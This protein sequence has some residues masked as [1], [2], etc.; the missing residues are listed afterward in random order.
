MIG[1]KKITIITHN[2]KFHTDDVFA[3]ATLQIALKS[4]SV[5]DKKIIVK[6]TRDKK[7]FDKGNYLVDIGGINDSDKNKF[8]HHQIGGA[9]EREN[10]IPYASFG[11]VWKKF[12]K[13]ICGSEEISSRIDEK[14]V[15]CA[16]AI[17]NG[18]DISEPIFP[19][20]RMYSV[21]DIV[22]SYRPTWKEI[23]K[24]IDKEFLKAVNWAKSVIERE[25]EKY[26]HFIE[27][28]KII[29]NRYNEARNKQL[30]IF[31][32]KNE[33][34]GREVIG[35]ILTQYPKVL[36][37]VFYRPDTQE[38]QILAINKNKDSFESRKPLPESWKGLRD[39]ELSEISGVDD[40]I[41]CHRTGFMCVTKTKEGAIKLAELALKD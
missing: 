33:G 22:D 41:F 18:V 6:R 23:G 35:G 29:E 7:W 25:I 40:A 28:E 13:K 10:G 37:T 11:L 34:F 16:D 8:D 31:H 26:K 9:G 39:K 30:V 36:Y 12:G 27:S 17:D 38:W 2:G 19:G 1:N 21:I 4:S 24:K 14:I 15:Q 3:V 5:N 32:D 20:I